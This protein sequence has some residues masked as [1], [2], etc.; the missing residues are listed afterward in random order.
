MGVEAYLVAS[1]LEAVLAQRLI[2]L[3]CEECKEELPKDEMRLLKDRYGDLVPEI[4]YRGRGCQICQQTGYIGR[5]GIFE[6]MVVT[7]EIRAMLLQN[8]SPQEIRKVAQ[9]Q[10]LRSLRQDGIRYLHSGQTTIEEVLR[11][12]KSE[13]INPMDKGS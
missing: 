4:L 5:A 8:V 3:I 1:S 11:V 7:E 2:R 6:Q 13:I 10:G 9:K 12:T